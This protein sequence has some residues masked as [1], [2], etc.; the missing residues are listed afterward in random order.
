MQYIKFTFFLSLLLLFGCSQKNE[1]PA[2]IPANAVLPSPQQRAY[3]QLEFVGF[4][5]FTVNTFTDKEWGYGDESPEI[6]NPV[7]LDAEQWARTAKAAGMQELILTAKHHDGFCLWPSA[8]TEHSIKSSPYKNGEGDIVQELVDACRKH[9]LKVGLYLSPWD[10]NHPDYGKPEYITYYRNQLRE[11]L[12]NYGEIN[13]IW[14]DGANGGDGYYGGANEV[15]KIDRATYYDW[16]TTFALVKELQPNIKIFSD[17]GP[18]LHWIGNE[19]GFAGET[20]WSTIQADSLVIGA[21]DPAYLNTGDPKGEDW[22]VGQCDVS[23]RPGWFY[24]AAQDDQVKSPQDLLDIYYKSVGRNAVLLINLPP[25]KQGLLHPNDIDSLLAFREILDE[26]FANNL[27]AEATATANN[28]RQ[29]HPKFAPAQV[30]DD[31]DSTYWATDEGV[32]PAELSLQFPEARTFDRLL[33]QEPI[34]LGQRVSAFRVEAKVD[35]QWQQLYQGTTIGYKRL[36]RMES[37]IADEI[38]LIVEAA[39]NTVAL[40][41]IEV[42]KASA[43]EM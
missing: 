28:F 21:S 16:P 13:E 2:D 35:G 29:N 37:V 4:I 22:I 40:S 32:L 25:N 8:Y 11:L 12:T 24:H 34:R 30:L 17:A 26:T 31:Q 3:Q 10:R 15:R 14:F 18:D 6:F 41:N 33:I 38:R 23:I 7:N 36:L 42:Y 20:F 27:A 43:R 19:H 39:N 1:I 5:H 9:G